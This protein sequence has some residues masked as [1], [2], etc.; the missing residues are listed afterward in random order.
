MTERVFETW[1]QVEA[2]A[3]RQQVLALEYLAQCRPSIQWTIED[4]IR[5]VIAA[6]SHLREIR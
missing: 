6:H 3:G 1:A 2:W 4:R 5:R